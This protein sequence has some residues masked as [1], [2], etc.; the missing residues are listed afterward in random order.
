MARQLYLLG[1]NRAFDVTADEFVP[2]SGGR[3]ARIA[4]LLQGGRDWQKHVPEYTRPWTA[5][6]VRH[7]DVIAPD[8]AGRLNLDVVVPQLEN[9]TGIFIGGGD[10]ATYQRLYVGDP[11][12]AILRKRYARGVPLA[13]CSAGAL[14]VPK[15]CAFHP[16]EGEGDARTANGLGLVDDLLVGVHFT[17]EHV[18]PHLLAAM[19]LTR[20]RTAW[21]IEDAACVVLEGEKF[22]RVCGRQ[23]YE[24]VMTDFDKGLYHL[25][26]HPIPATLE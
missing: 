17:S 16:G 15:I 1:G 21:G 25:L 26:E 20:T 11:V 22:A 4:L 2:A 7:C 5:R 12:R 9:A 3:G 13:G 23:A 8:A 10:T 24:I 19:A 18:L 6:G 14:I